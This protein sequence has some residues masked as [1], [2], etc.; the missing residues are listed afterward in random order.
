MWWEDRA[1]GCCDLTRPLSYIS[2]YRLGYVGKEWGSYKPSGLSGLVG[3]VSVLWAELLDPSFCLCFPLEDKLR[4]AGTLLLWLLSRVGKMAQ[5]QL[6]RYVT[7]LQAK[8][9]WTAELRVI[10][11]SCFRAWLWRPCGW[12]GPGLLPLP[13][14]WLLP[15]HW[16][17][18][19][20]SGRPR[21]SNS[22]L[23]SW[24][25]RDPE[26]SLLHAV[27]RIM[28]SPVFRNKLWASLCIPSQHCQSCSAKFSRL[29][30]FVH[31]CSRTSVSFTAHLGTSPCF[32][33]PTWFR[34][35]PLCLPWGPSCG[36]AGG[37]G[38]PAPHHSR[39]PGLQ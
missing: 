20:S 15:R 29:R 21:F 37:G 26:P 12:Q 24:D 10:G 30:S 35:C 16:A 11:R 18:A 2:A 14:A 9:P 31:L 5:E 13:P 3:A 27:A 32:T 4:E 1:E 36:G 34:K 17:S 28:F 7:T 22:C 8:N 6:C 23:G 39:V 33:V 25:P 19:T 38:T